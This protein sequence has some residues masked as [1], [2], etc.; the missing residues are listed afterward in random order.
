MILA[1]VTAASST[2]FGD[3]GADSIQVGA[4]TVGITG[5]GLYGDNT[6]SSEGGND[7]LTLNAGSLLSK[8]TVSG[9]AGADTIVLATTGASSEMISSTVN[10]NAGNDSISVNV[11]GA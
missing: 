5:I 6:T 10:A 3:L 8:A 9:G 1:A 7:T 2:V 11:A 4:T